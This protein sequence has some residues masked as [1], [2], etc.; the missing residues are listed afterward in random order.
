MKT[1]W[2]ALL[3]S[4]ICFEGL[5]RRY[6]PGV[7]A[8]A[9]YFLKDLVLVYGFVRYRPALPVWRAARRLYRG[10]EIVWVLS[11]MW[12]V[13]ELFNPEHQSATL[14]LI[15]FR[16]YWLWW[17][18]PALVAQV[19]RDEKERRRAI[20]VLVGAA[21]IVAAMAAVQFVSPTDSSVA[22]Y[23]YVD[24][25]RIDQ[26]VISETGRGR[27]ASTFAFISGFADFSIL[28]P[29]LLLS[30]GLDT[31]DATLRRNAFIATGM[32]A[33]VLPMAGSRLT[34]LV[35]AGILLISVWTAGIFF[36][37]VG[38]RLLI[39]GVAAV[40]VAAVVFP[41]ALVGVQSR[42][43]NEEETQHRYLLTAASVLPPLAIGMVDHPAFGIGTG[44]LQNA[45][46]A[47]GVRATY[48]VEQEFERYLVEL[49][50]FGY[51]LVWTVKFGL[52]IAL[53]RAYSF[54]KRAGRR[55][56][57]TAAL[58][59]A[60]LTMVGNLTFDHVWQALYFIG[61]GFI[62]A[63]IVAVLRTAAPPIP[64]PQFTVAAVSAPVSVP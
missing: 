52:S 25:E 37:R 1:A 31:K 10:F 22:V 64:S 51:L 46:G 42:F 38:R 48:E 33:A 29:T 26:V 34:V 41:D 35:G 12:T 63:E 49:G 3:I 27:V 17:L 7:P 15:G 20:Y 45:R 55:G 60:I 23:S 14:A 43:G 53:F 11:F 8:A 19:L 16:A 57:S 39:S 2:F 18:A 58:S 32:I 40:T 50:T 44:M 9:F 13:V 47:L 21:G 24:G 30:L 59:Y 54:L 5:G 4:T 6:F 62:L 28:I 61:C 56:A 36:T